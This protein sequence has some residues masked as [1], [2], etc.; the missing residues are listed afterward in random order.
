MW[1]PRVLQFMG[2][3]RVRHYLVIKWLNNKS[4]SKRWPPSYKNYC[5]LLTDKIKFLRMSIQ[6]CFPK[7]HLL[8]SIFT[9]VIKHLRAI[10][11]NILLYSPWLSFLYFSQMNLQIE[12]NIFVSITKEQYNILWICSF[13]NILWREHITFNIMKKS[14]EGQAGSREQNDATECFCREEKE[15]RKSSES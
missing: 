7:C 11:E 12:R 10:F 13:L 9:F 6:D 14:W 5:I 4:K 1:K 2:F 15:N 3:Q 8:S